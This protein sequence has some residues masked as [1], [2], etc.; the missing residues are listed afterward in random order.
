MPLPPSDE[1]HPTEG[2][3]DDVFEQLLGVVDSADDPQQLLAE[4]GAFRDRHAE[5]AAAIDTLVAKLCGTPT[6]PGSGGEIPALIGPYHV[7]DRL[8][9]GGMGEVYRAERREPVRQLVA[10][11]VV[12]RGLATREVLARFRIER[13]ALAVMSHP[14]I[15]RVFDAGATAAGEPYFVM[16]FVHG[17]PLTEH[18]DRHCLSIRRRLELLRQISSAVHH[19]HL[20]GI[21]HRDLKPG[22]VLVV[23]EGDAEVPKVL[24]FGLAKATNRDFLDVTMLT[25]KDRILGTLEYMSPEQ[26]AG[27][28]E[29]VDAR[30]DIY[31][32]G[33]IMYELL[34]GELPFP[35]D[36]LRRVGM[37]EALRMIRQEEP[38]KPSSRIA[39]GDPRV[40]EQRSS[41][42]SRLSRDLR[43]ELDWIVLKAMAKEP[44]R[45][46][47][48][49]AEFAR[50]LTR[51]LDHEPVLAG[52]P[53][54][55]YRLRKFVQRYRGPITAATAVLLA[56]V[57]GL[58]VS[59]IFYRDAEAKAWQVE[60]QRR[61]LDVA[62]NSLRERNDRFDMLSYV[63]RMRTIVDVEAGLHPAWPDRAKAID[64]WLRE[65][66]DQLTAAL[67]Q[68]R[69]T[70][71]AL[72][73][74]KVSAAAGSESDGFLRD[75]LADLV[76][77]IETFERDTVADVER[78]LRWA[79]AIEGLT[80]AHPNARVGWDA[81]RSVLGTSELYG[82]D[83]ITLAPQLGLVPLGTNPR[84][85]LLEFYHL[86]S[87]WDG[88]SDPAA[89][90]I[91]MHDPDDGT[92]PVGEDT[93]IVFVLVPGGTFTMGAQASDPRSPSFDP[94]AEA[95][96]SPHRVTLAPFFIARHEL[97]QGQWERLRS[98]ALPSL[99][100]NYPAGEENG[101]G[102]RV[103]LAHPVESVDHESCRMLMD[104]HGLVLPT[105]AQWE[106]ACRAGTATPWWTGADRESLVRPGLVANIADES[107]RRHGADWKEIADWPG[108]DDGH[109]LH[110]P[111]DTYRDNPWGLHCVHGNVYEWCADE[112]GS[113]SGP[114]RA[115]DGYRLEP[116]GSHLRVARDG[117]FVGPVRFTRASFRDGLA[118][119]FRGN[120]LGMR[121]ARA[122]RP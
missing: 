48:S 55:G 103:T 87:A 68:L 90:E 36:V 11:K 108:Y 115:G 47:D 33:V 58:V 7:L 63:V 41:Q 64:S 15:A 13:R 29:V 93:G 121:A 43:R 78:R 26:A 99:P 53:S 50:E 46:Y 14:S 107:A 92:I 35:T 28:G 66:A 120:D 31:S 23:H 111:V 19:A 49:A 100:S 102:G 16:E 86:R 81:V 45:R 117:A 75:T 2:L 89:I 109:L 20:K 39:S 113:Y 79:R 21:V 73:E 74:V 38:Q 112:Y 1:P 10:I 101:M 77:R 116:D 52:P 40:A 17:V 76:E 60:Q 91:P 3:P 84:T 30:S 110:A 70:I 37:H 71:A 27:D 82:T 80:S 32:L 34:T 62:A 85:G 18:C 72:G 6:G 69:K 56:T 67:P 54:A 61:Q 97:T 98:G 65:D 95:D 12:K 42:L 44:E 9:S 24:D 106:Y 5:H 4:V 51:Y 59:L 88:D 118:P 114:V 96:E 22:N 104:H 105:E 8:G 122:I 25:E 119:G 57:C 94:L 83:R